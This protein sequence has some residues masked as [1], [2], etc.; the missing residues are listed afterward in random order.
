[1]ADDEEHHKHLV[2]D[3]L[4]M[5]RIRLGSLENGLRQASA[6]LKSSED[7]V[8]QVRAGIAAIGAVIDFINSFSD[9]E[10]DGLDL[11]LRVVLSA[12]DDV[13][14]DIRSPLMDRAG[15]ED[16][17]LEGLEHGLS[18]A[19]EYMIGGIDTKDTALQ[20]TA[21]M[22]ALRAAITF[23]STDAH[24]KSE[25]LLRPFDMLFM[26]LFDVNE[27]KHSPILEPDP[28]QHRPSDTTLGTSCKAWAALAMTMVMENRVPKSKAAKMV[29]ER[30][31]RSGY[32]LGGGKP[33]T[34]RAV[35]SWRERCIRHHGGTAIGRAYDRM[36]E[37]AQAAG[38][39]DVDAAMRLADAAGG[40]VRMLVT[41]PFSQ[42]PKKPPS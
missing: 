17:A 10:K 27:G 32:K 20:R 35:A 21:T 16:D 14:K 39:R 34:P 26:A 23:L 19:T 40:G 28:P 38:K 1:M 8:Y 2:P 24:L 13:E 3:A 31:A 41:G 11:P 12:F 18:E 7:P 29:A 25:G 22:M 4:T 6:T 36:N 5:I 9:L 33:P 42:N 15:Q 30:M 37:M